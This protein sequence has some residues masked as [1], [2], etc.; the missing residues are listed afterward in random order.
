M[1]QVNILIPENAPV[2]LAVPIQI[3]VSG[4][5]TQSGVTIAIQ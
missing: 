5:N 2:G 1:Q 3:M 4:V